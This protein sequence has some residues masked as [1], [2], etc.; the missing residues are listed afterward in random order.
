MPTDKEKATLTRADLRRLV[1][2][3]VPTLGMAL[4]VTVVTTLLPVVARGFGAS[5]AVIGLLIASEGVMA[6]WVPVLAGSRSDRL[7]TPIGGRLPFLLAGTPVMVACLVLFGQLGSLVAIAVAV[8][9]FFAGY[10]LAYEPYRALYPDLVP[11]AAAGRSQSSQATARGLGTGL[12]LVGGGVLLSIARPLPFA[13][14]AAVLLLGVGSFTALMLRGGR[15]SSENEERAEGGEDSAWRRL[16]DLLRDRRELR[17]YVVANA[18]WELSLAAIK[19]FVVLYVTKG[20]G[21]SLSQAS[22]LIGAVAFVV[23]AGALASGSLADRFG[24]VRV[25]EVG[26]WIY[27]AALLVPGLTTTTLAVAASVPFIAFGGGMQ[28]SLPYSILMPLMP[29]DEHGLLTGLYSLSR[30]IGVML[31]PVIAGLA[32][33]VMEP[34]MSSSEGYAAAWLI[35]AA[36]ILASIPILRALQPAVSKASR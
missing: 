12:A 24:R 14:S 27:G 34:L 6:L 15:A 5:T 4:A 23:L 20:L 16:V 35:S 26:L 36:A 32:I 29:A 30:G 2:L 28:M 9:V 11:D 33:T 3:A 22:A 17:L 7:R 19:T 31:G 1:V 8:A 13:L 10:Y 18:L 25:M 21:Y